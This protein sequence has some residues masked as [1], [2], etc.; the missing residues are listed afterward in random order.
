MST[1]SVT[2]SAAVALTV[3]FAST[4][5]DLASIVRRPRRPRPVAN[6]RS[7]AGLL[8]GLQDRQGLRRQLHLAQQSVPCPAR[9]RLQR[10]TATRHASSAA[11]EYPQALRR[12]V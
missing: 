2:V 3:A 1:A 6:S 11:T 7:G 9:L 4:G 12:A 10:L 8:P 5:V